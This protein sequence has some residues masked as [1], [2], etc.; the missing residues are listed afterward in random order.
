PPG[1]YCAPIHPEPHLPAMPLDPPQPADPHSTEHLQDHPARH[2]DTT[3]RPLTSRHWT[4]TSQV[5]RSAASRSRSLGAVQP[6]TCLSARKAVLP[7]PG[8]A[9]P[10]AALLVLPRDGQD[11]QGKVPPGLHLR[12][13]RPRRLSGE[14]RSAERSVVGHRGRPG[15]LPR[16]L[17]AVPRRP[18][19]ARGVAA[20]PDH[21]QQV[22]RLGS[23]HEAADAA[24]VLPQR[25][26][27]GR[28]VRRSCG[29]IGRPPSCAVPVRVGRVFDKISNRTTLVLPAAQEH[30]GDPVVAEALGITVQQGAARR[31]ACPKG[32]DYHTL[33]SGRPARSERP[34]VPP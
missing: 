18:G 15:G 21:D 29:P 4:T 10:G 13:P 9:A 2:L 31:H 14:P 3:P 25:E 16:V 34:A 22:L 26:R 20:T 7:R 11:E 27:P 32:P 5:Q 33:S 12:L 8:H 17:H 19:D 30:L 6:S 1:T 28:A 23:G 24:A